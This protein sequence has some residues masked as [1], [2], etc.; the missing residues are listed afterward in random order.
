MKKVAV[1]A[2]SSTTVKLPKDCGASDVNALTPRKRAT[3]FGAD[4]AT[5]PCGARSAL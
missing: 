5:Q 3:S 2:L 4:T 1:A